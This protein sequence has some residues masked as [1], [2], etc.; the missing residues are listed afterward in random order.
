MDKMANLWNILKFSIFVK[1]IN[2]FESPNI[3]D[4]MKRAACGRPS[5]F[6]KQKNVFLNSEVTK[7]KHLK[8]V[9]MP[10]VP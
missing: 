7:Y 1:E 4:V 9:F 6:I 5:T 8:Q 3:V 10:K 2:N